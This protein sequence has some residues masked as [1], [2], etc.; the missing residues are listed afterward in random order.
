MSSTKPREIILLVLVS[1]LLFFA[2]GELVLRIYLTRHTFYD[3]EMS[4]YARLLKIDTANPLTGHHHRPDTQARLMN[5]T[6]RTNSDGFRDDDYPV[7]K[8]ARRRI[9]F[10]GDSLTLG[11]GVE[12]EE[13]FEHLLERELDAISPAEIINLGIGNYNTTQEVNLFLD[14]GLKYSPDQVVLFYFINDAEPAPQ[15]SRFPWLGEIRIVNFYWSRAKALA[16]RLSEARGFQAYYSALYRDGQ[17]GWARSQ[18]ALLELQRICREH[19][20]Q[21]QVVLLPELHE[22]QDYPFAKEHGLIT[23]FLRENEIPA[24]DL[25]PSFHDERNPTTLWVAIDDAHPNAEAHRR[26]AEYSLEF[27]AG[28]KRP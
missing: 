17:P 1:L 2:F 21:L 26:I 3:V 22:L 27:I 12:K 6:V 15:K 25:A 10:L 5:V 9:I 20:L 14:K 28:T 8:G 23:D 7:E 13:T 19:D 11:W 24:L 16:E 4:R 18:A